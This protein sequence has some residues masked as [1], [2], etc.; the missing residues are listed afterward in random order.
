MVVC[1]WWVIPVINCQAAQGVPQ[2]STKVSWDWFHLPPWPWRISRID[3]GW[4]D[5][6]IQRAKEVIWCKVV[7]R[8]NNQSGDIQTCCMLH[9]WNIK[10]IYCADVWLILAKST[11]K[12]SLSEIVY[13]L[14]TGRV[15]VCNFN[16]GLGFSVLFL[17]S[18][19]QVPLMAMSHQWPLA[20][21]MKWTLQLEHTQV[22]QFKQLYWQFLQSLQSHIG[23]LTS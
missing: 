18:V 23:L 4:L 12:Q 20:T 13:R 8:T 22:W 15:M 9:S 1:L 21:Q 10:C 19:C 6:W 17:S 16:C 5:G 2:L 7:G 3:N 14:S 11:E